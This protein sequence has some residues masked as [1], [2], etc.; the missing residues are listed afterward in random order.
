MERKIKL[1]QAQEVK[2][3]V[4]AAERCDFNVDVERMNRSVDGK[5]LFGVISLGLD[6]SVTVKYL[7]ND[8]QFEAVL[9]HAFN[10]GWI[11]DAI[12]FVQTNVWN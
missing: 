1:S 9:E 6:K 5:S 12:F 7:G 8:P 11:V 4:A 2:E 3:F 10:E